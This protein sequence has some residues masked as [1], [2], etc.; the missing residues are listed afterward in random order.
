MNCAV[1]PHR[2]LSMHKFHCDLL[3][4]EE[5]RTYFSTK[6]GVN[7]MSILNEV[8]HFDL[9]LCLPHDIMH[10]I[11]EGVLPRN[12]RLLLS[13][14]IIQ[15]HYFSLTQLNKIIA[16]FKFGDYEKGNSPRPINRDRLSSTGDKLGQSG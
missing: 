2:N 3:N 15:K 7:R 8:Q 4:Q 10:V 12:F 5:D 14:C 13:H 6:Y 1:L 11:L 9:T 16:S